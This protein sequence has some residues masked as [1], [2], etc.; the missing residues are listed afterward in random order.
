MNI[1]LRGQV[2]TGGLLLVLSVFLGQHTEKEEASFP[3]LAKLLVGIAGLV[4]F[5]VYVNV[6]LPGLPCE[7][8]SIGEIIRNPS[9]PESAKSLLVTGQIVG[10]ITCVM[11]FYFLI[12]TQYRRIPVYNLR[13]KATLLGG[14]RLARFRSKR[15]SRLRVEA[16]GRV[17]T[18]PA[19]P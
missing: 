7:L 16:S 13:E 11:T 18:P 19:I 8:Y 17:R 5:G 9:L 12:Y 4:A 1:L 6:P 15:S 3:K 14:K 10:T 2:L